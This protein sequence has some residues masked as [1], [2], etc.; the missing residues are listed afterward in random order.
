MR[1]LFV[2]AAGLLLAGCSASPAP[3]PTVTATTTA[4]VETTVTA[5]PTVT[6]TVTAP[7]PAPVSAIDEGMWTVGTDIAPGK[8]RT[9]D[10]VSD[11]C[12]WAITRSGSN[13]DDIVANANV[14]GGHPVVVLK[15]GQDFDTEGC[16]SW[17]K[18]R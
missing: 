11:G 5:T 16:G 15:R 4:T 2:V 10:A 3:A 17:A 18:A 6:V 7:P 13:G 1:G 8:Y 9:I 14:T 12:Y